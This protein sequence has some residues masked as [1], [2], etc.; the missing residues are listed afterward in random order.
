MLYIDV[1]PDPCQD[2]VGCAP[3]R[4]VYGQRGHTGRSV[5]VRYPAALGPIPPD[6]T[7]PGHIHG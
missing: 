6:L 7:N 1:P 5:P 4:S 3:L 2:F